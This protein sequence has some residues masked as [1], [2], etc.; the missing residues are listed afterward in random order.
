MS[1]SKTFIA[2]LSDPLDAECR[3]ARRIIVSSEALKGTKL[4]AGDAVALVSAQ[5][6]NLNGAQRAVRRLSFLAF[7]SLD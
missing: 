1:F 3:G 7:S 4:T 5:T 2:Q 6:S